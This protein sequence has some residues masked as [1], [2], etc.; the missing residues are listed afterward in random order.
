MY[1]T[2]IFKKCFAD[3]ATLESLC[4]TLIMTGL[5]ND[6]YSSQYTEEA[7]K[8][9][10][11]FGI[12]KKLLS[13]ADENDYIIIADTD[14][15]DKAELV[16]SRINSAITVKNPQQHVYHFSDPETAFSVHP[17]AN[18]AVVNVSSQYAARVCVQCLEHDLGLLVPSVISYEDEQKMKEIALLKGLPMLGGG[19]AGALI[20]DVALG[21]CPRFTKGNTAVIGPSFTANMYA[22]FL[23]ERSGIGIR[24]IISTGRRDYFTAE[25]GRMTKYCIDMLNDDPETSTIVF[26]LKAGD[27]EIIN[28]V[29]DYAKNHSDKKIYFYGAGRLKTGQFTA[30]MDSE[31][32]V[33]ALVGRICED[34]GLPLPELLSD[35]DAEAMASGY[36]SRISTAQKYVRGFLLSDAMCGEVISS[37]QQ[38]IGTI[39]SNR[40]IKSSSMLQDARSLKENSIIDYGH[41]SLTPTCRA[42]FQASLSRNRRLVA[43]SYNRTVAVL[44]A[45]WYGGEGCTEAYLNNLADSI[46]RCISNAAADGRTIA[47]AVIAATGEYSPV[48][49]Q[50]TFET[51]KAAGAEVFSNADDAAL[52]A[53]HLLKTTEVN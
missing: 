22:A 8:F 37:L 49:Y 41:R 31:D 24:H 48:S 15:A 11:A 21:A 39:Y 25:L 44:I 42:A 19:V 10:G 2:H 18:F 27:I 29:V 28:D 12:D 3:P 52:F 46:R 5:A 13:D 6:I 20:G 34:V 40:P 9:S 47:V 1:Y 53:S 51:L 26:I 14:S 23:L 4:D 32:S 43:E 33:P 7:E 36:R 17:D 38:S 45:D 30:N 35:A 50:K 16:F